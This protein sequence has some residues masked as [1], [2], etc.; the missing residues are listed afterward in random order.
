MFINLLLM[1][2][3]SFSYEIVNR[4]LVCAY[5]NWLL[6]ILIDELVAQQETTGSEELGHAF[7]TDYDVLQII[8]SRLNGTWL[9]EVPILSQGC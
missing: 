1:W 5:N 2:P 3:N 9:G 6:P 8:E 4:Q 7:L